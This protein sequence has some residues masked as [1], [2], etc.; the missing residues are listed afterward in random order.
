MQVYVTQGHEHGIGLEVFFK[1]CLLLSDDELT[2]VKLIA[3]PL[4]VTETLSLLKIPFEITKTGLTLCGRELSVSWCKKM[5]HS[6]SHTA[7]IEGMK[8][9]EEGGVLYTLPTSKDQF[10]SSAGHT[11]YFRQVY[12]TPEL[13]MFFSSPTLQVLLLTDHVAISELSKVLTQELIYKKLLLALQTLKRWNWPTEQILISGLNPH[14][15]ENG[16]IGHEDERIKKA[17]KQLLDKNKFQVSGPFPGDTMLLEKG[18]AKD[19]LVYLFHDQGLGVFKGIQG[20][21]GSNITLGLPYP[22]FSPDHGTS[23]S[24]FGKNVAD[25]RGCAFSLRQAIDLTRMSDGQNYSYQS[26]R[27]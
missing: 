8:R 4:A 26:T 27:S 20:F 14:A 3:F 22:R 2:S 25:Y 16:M 18:S 7:L 10:I 19:V 23:F 17:I 9:S 21:I 11:E 13:G 5:I 15:G 1:T 24:L 12:K 6:Q